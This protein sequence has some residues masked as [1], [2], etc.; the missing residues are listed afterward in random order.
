VIPCSDKSIADYFSRNPEASVDNFFDEFGI[1]NP[2][3]K[4][5]ILYKINRIS[6]G[7]VEEGFDSNDDLNPL[8]LLFNANFFLEAKIKEIDSLN[9]P[10][11]KK[12]VMKAPYSNAY[13]S[14]SKISSGIADEVNIILKSLNKTL[15]SQKRREQKMEQIFRGMR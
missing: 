12:M 11:Y 8:E 15:N 1:L 7:F 3:D 9:L 13:Y 10:G 14:L 4:Q 2:G 5:V 6:E